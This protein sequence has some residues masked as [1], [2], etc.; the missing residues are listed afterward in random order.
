MF[1]F[2]TRPVLP[3]C[4][5]NVDGTTWPELQQPLQQSPAVIAAS[6]YSGLCV[7]ANAINA[8]NATKLLDWR[9]KSG[10]A[11]RANHLLKH[12]QHRVPH[13]SRCAEDS[14]HRRAIVQGECPLFKLVVGCRAIRIICRANMHPHE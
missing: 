3:C 12:L 11:D 10:N 8:T 1:R 4:Q 5:V 2:L 9:R 6:K 7:F 13:V 14:D